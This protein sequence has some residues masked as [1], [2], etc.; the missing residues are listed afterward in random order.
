MIKLKILLSIFFCGILVYPQSEKNM[1]SDLLSGVSQISV[2]IGGNFPLTGS[3]RASAVER[4]DQLVTRIYNQAYTLAL[5][6][7]PTPQQI[8]NVKS[9]FEKY[10]LRNIILRRQNGE[11]LKIDLI[12]FRKTGSFEYNPYLKN[13][14]V[15]IFPATDLERNFFTVS[16]AV[17]SEGK[18]HY[19]D[20]DKLSDAIFLADGINLAYENVNQAE[21]TRLSYD[22]QRMDNIIVNINS[23]FELKRGDRI[24]IL[25]D[26]TQRKVYNVLALGEFRR[27]GLIP[28]KKENTHLK[29]VL[30][31][32]GGFTEKADL[33]NAQI[34]RGVN[35][36]KYLAFSE[37]IEKLQMMRMSTLVSDDS[38]YFKIDE[39][40]RFLRGN[41]NVDFTQIENLS[42]TL[43]TLRDGDIIYIPSKIDLV[44]V[45]GQ[46]NEPAYVNFVQGKDLNFYISKAGGLGETA[47]GDVYLIKG[48]TRTWVSADEYK[49][50]GVEIEP[51]DYI[52]ASKKPVRTFWYHVEQAS[53]IASIVGGIATVILLFIQ[54]GK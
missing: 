49:A 25:A 29:E 39:D 21:I 30:I 42:D 6:N 23:D 28:I 12:K 52:W 31:K 4:V 3:Y 43:F 51:G 32:T 20:G 36:F 15:L 37:E 46:V 11:Q 16:G 40:L 9:E 50:L 54:A 7:S 18:F 22:G 24:R 33:D 27:P 41:V 14:D 5:G 45:Y 34:I 19:F 26:E 48:K 13:D 47:S 1:T 8:A 53:K 10:A 2:T 44:Y 35:V 38:I 17:N